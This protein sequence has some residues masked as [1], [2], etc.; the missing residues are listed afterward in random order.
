MSGVLVTTGAMRSCA[1][2]MS[3]MVIGSMIRMSRSAELD[4]H[5]GSR[6]LGSIVDICS[7]GEVLD[8]Q[9]KRLEERDLAFVS[10]ADAA[11]D[12]QFA[13]LGDN[14]IGKNLA[15]AKRNENIARLLER[16]FAA[17]DI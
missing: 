4:A 13:H 1:A 17:V 15:V 2:R 9:T 5:T 10:T 7:G 3:S 16:R 12:Q 14:M 11:S 8:R 6:S